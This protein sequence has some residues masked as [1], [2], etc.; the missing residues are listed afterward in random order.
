MLYKARL[1]R[2]TGAME[3]LGAAR[4]QGPWGGVASAVVTRQLNVAVPRLVR[5]MRGAARPRRPW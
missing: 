4:L 2:C 1:L 3:R 5:E